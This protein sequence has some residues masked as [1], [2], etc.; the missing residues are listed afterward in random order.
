MI[1]NAEAYWGYDFD[2][3][4]TATPGNGSHVVAN[5]RFK[6]WR[7]NTPAKFTFP[8]LVS[9]PIF[10]NGGT[11]A[12]PAAVVGYSTYRKM[13]WISTYPNWN[14][15]LQFAPVK[16]WYPAASAPF[17]VQNVNPLYNVTVTIHWKGRKP[18]F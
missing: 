5:P 15:P 4:Y 16:M 17:A 8:P 11:A 13:G 2:D 1:N 10:L 3:S 7:V 12:A 18:D 6:R 9:T 14:V